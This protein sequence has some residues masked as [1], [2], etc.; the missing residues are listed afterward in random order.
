MFDIDIATERKIK[1]IEKKARIPNGTIGFDVCTGIYL[2][3]DFFF[4][5]RSKRR[6]KGILPELKAILKKTVVAAGC[7]TCKV[8]INNNLTNLTNKCTG[9]KP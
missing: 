5:K 7:P 3:N 1:K 9:Q 6:L 2:L 8:Y 4:T